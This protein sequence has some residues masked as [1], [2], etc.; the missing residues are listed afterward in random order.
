[1]HLILLGAP[2]AGKGT[3]AKMLVDKLGIP[4]ISTGDMLRAARKSGSDLGKKVSKIMDEG[5]LVSDDIVLALVKE[6]LSQADA[7]DGAIFDGYPRTVAQA[8]ALGQLAQIDHVLSIDVPEA[9]LSARLTGRRTCKACGAM[10]HLMFKPSKTEGV[11]DKCGGETY[12]RQDDNEESIKNRLSVYH[13]STAPLIRYYS[14]RNV[15]R[16]I[17]GVGSMSDI[18]SRIEQ[19]MAGSSGSADQG[20]LR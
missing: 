16:E 2:G 15:L 17:N 14:E 13:S 4:Q 11:C 18:T 6:R 19:A 5:G 1:M 7:A 12:Q 20:G 3:Q 9:D 10:Y 8:E